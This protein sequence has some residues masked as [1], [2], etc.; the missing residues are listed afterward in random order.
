MHAWTHAHK[1]VRVHTLLLFNVH[2]YNNYTHTVP[3]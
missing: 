2:Y 1:V 3:I